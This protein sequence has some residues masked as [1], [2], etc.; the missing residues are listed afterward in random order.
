VCEVPGP[1]RVALFP[2]PKFQMYVV[3]GNKGKLVL[4]LKKFTVSGAHPLSGEWVK[5]ATGGEI[6]IKLFITI[7]SVQV[8]LAFA[9]MSETV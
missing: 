7:V 9:A 3:R 8:P 4:V 1:G 6:V 5:P 2:S